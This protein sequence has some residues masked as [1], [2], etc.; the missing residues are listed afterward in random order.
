MKQKLLVAF[1][2][3]SG[4]RFRKPVV[5]LNEPAQQGLSLPHQLHFIRTA[6]KQSA[7]GID[8]CLQ[9]GYRAQ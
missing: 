1:G 6:G 9:P 4:E 5:A 2:I 3:H 8:K 7:H